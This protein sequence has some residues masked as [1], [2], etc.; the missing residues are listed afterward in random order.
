MTTTEYDWWWGKQIN[1]SVP[2]SSTRPIEEHLQVFPTKLEIVKQDF[3]KKSSE[4]RKR[5]EK[6]EEENI[7]LGLDVNV[8][9]SRVAELERSLHQHRSRNF[10]IEWKASLTE[11]EEF[12]GN[13]EELDAV[14][15]NCELRVELLEMNN[16]HWKEQ[17]QHSQGQIRD[18]DHIMGKALTQVQEVADHLQTLAV[19]IDILSLR[20]ESESDLGRELAWL[21]RKVKALNIRAMFII[22]QLTQLLFGGIEKGKSTVIN[23]GDDNE[24]PTY[25]QAVNYSTGSSSN[26]EDNSTNPVVLDLDD[27]AEI[28][29]A[30]IE[31]P[32][33]LEDWCKWL[34]HVTDMTP[35]RITLQNMEKKQNESFRQYAQRWREVAIQTQPPLLEKEAKMFINTL[36]APFIN[37]M[38]GSATKSFLDIVMFKEMLKNVVKSGKI[39]GGKR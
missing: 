6:L 38:L 33:Q 11:I 2:S 27:M 1:D 18:K 19:Q 23:S 13:I 39:N 10:V 34:D 20:Y 15:Q 31:F 5:M 9:K 22:R 29:R 25:P 35:D 14:L 17:L 3:E 36:K 16:E 32:K 26:P 37:H 4:L 24:D 12:K 28:D 8:Q 7:Q 30:I 21:L